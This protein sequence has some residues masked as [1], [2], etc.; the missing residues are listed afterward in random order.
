MRPGGD[1]GLCAEAKQD[2]LQHAKRDTGNAGRAGAERASAGR[3]E[4]AKP[5]GGAVDCGTLCFD[6]ISNGRHGSASIAEQ[7]ITLARRQATRNCGSN[8]IYI[9]GRSTTC[10]AARV[11]LLWQL[12]LDHNQVGVQQQIGSRWRSGPSMGDSP[13]DGNPAS[14]RPIELAGDNMHYRSDSGVDGEIRMWERKKERKKGH[15]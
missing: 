4:G 1:V 6:L 13:V 5:F 8:Y 2:Y 14:I 3:A 7:R 15:Y 11:E 9:P 10:I 12:R